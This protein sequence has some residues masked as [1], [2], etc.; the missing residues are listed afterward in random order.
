MDYTILDM[1]PSLDGKKEK[2]KRKNINSIRI[3]THSEK[4]T[5]QYSC[6]PQ[7]DACFVKID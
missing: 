1:Y 2:E 6:T 7:E 4:R 3:P 5:M